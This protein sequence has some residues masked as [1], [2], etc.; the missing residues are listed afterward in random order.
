MHKIFLIAIL[1]YFGVLATLFGIDPENAKEEVKKRLKEISVAV[2]QHK[3][4]LLMSYWTKD[5][6]WVNPTTGEKLKGNAEIAESLQK[7][8]QEIEKRNFLL[9]IT[10]ENITF[11]ASDKAVVDAIVEIKDKKG[12][13]IQR[14]E[15]TI[16]LVNQDGKWYVN[17]VREVEITPPLPVL[18]PLK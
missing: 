7:R 2:Q 16:T 1:C 10:P 6:Q 13:L 12:Q 17:Q 5:A 14:Y 3:T 11:P 4:D 15:R 8:T 18:S 9:T